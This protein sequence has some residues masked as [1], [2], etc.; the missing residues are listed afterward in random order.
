M[1]EISVDKIP[2]GRID[3]MLN[4][5]VKTAAAIDLLYAMY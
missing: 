5:P 1:E 4:D 2:A 3:K